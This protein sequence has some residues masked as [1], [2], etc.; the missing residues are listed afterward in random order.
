VRKNAN[1]SSINV[2][3]NVE[4]RLITGFRQKPWPA[5]LST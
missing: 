4:A 2:T 1:S 3:V 5:A